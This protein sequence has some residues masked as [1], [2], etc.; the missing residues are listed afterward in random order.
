VRILNKGYTFKLASNIKGLGKFE[1]VMVVYLDDNYR[2]SHIYLQPQT[3]AKNSLKYKTCWH[4][5]ENLVGV[6]I[7]NHTYR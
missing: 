3:K 6:N 7:T 4:I 5:R 2:K 1:D